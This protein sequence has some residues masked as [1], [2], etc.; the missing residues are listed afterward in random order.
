MIYQHITGNEICDWHNFAQEPVV[1]IQR[2]VFMRENETNEK[3]VVVGGGF[4]GL[5]LVKRLDKSRFEICLVDRNNYHGFPPLFYQ[6]ASSGLDPT[7]ISFPLRREMKKRGKGVRFHIG[8]V[9]EIDVSRKVV[10]TQ[11]EEIPYDKLI[12]AVGTTNN[13]FG[14]DKLIEQVFTLKSTDEAIR[15]RNEILARCERAAIEPD[16]EKRRRLMSFTVIGG[17]PAGVEIAGALGEMKRYILKRDYPEIPMEDVSIRLIEGSDRLLHTMSEKSS[18]DA[19]RDLKSLLVDI[20]LQ[21]VMKEYKDNVITLEDGTAIYSEMVIWTAGVTGTP[22]KLTGTEV[23]R[24]P[25]NRLITDEYCRV[26]EIDDVYAI[27]DINYTETTLYPRGYPQLAQVAIQQGKFLADMLNRGEA[28]KPF[29]YIDKGSMATIGRNRAVADMKHV[30]FDGWWAW[31]IWM[32]VHLISLLGMRN[33]L[34]VLLNWMWS[35][36]T[37]NTALRLLLRGSRYP[38]RGMMRDKD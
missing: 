18:R 23:K 19:F 31:M 22:F 29:K 33:K 13:F 9:T 5:N 3:V 37:Y 34:N 12:L 2:F 20:K 26:K 28:K 14:N 15:C 17:G 4:A 16:A 6:V 7:S 35:Y 27:G 24:G 30:H 32:F 36:F 38:L 25:G 21:H 1:I 8:D 11:Y 10:I